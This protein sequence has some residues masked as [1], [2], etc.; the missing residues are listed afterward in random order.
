MR[1]VVGPQQLHTGIRLGEKGKT[2]WLCTSLA[3]ATSSPIQVSPVEVVSLCDVDKRM[4]E[5]GEKRG[6]RQASH[7]KPRL[8][9]DYR[10]MLKEKDLD[11]V[12]VEAPDHWTPCR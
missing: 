1:G 2:R 9:G 12:L 8:Y 10:E 6:V 7:K 3:S 4:S 11:V 5:G